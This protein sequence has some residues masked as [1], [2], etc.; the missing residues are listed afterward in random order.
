MPLVIVEA[1]A[2][3]L[4]VVARKIPG[5]DE[6]V[7]DGVTGW[8]VKSPVDAPR[9]VLAALLAAAACKTLRDVGSAKAM[10]AAARARFLK[11]FTEETMIRATTAVWSELHT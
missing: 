1:M 10:R 2:V 9:N 11:G 7:E 5:I 8:L 3:G 4:P 6:L